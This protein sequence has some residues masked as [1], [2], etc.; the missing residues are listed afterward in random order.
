MLRKKIVYILFGVLLSFK[1]F[2]I[3]PQII[4]TSEIFNQIKKIDLDKTR[5]SFNAT[6]FNSIVYKNDSTLFYN[7]QGTL[8]LFKIKL[9]VVTKVT[10][11]SKPST[12][13]HAYN[14][15]L[16]FHKNKIYNYGGEGSFH[17][18]PGLIYF[19]DLT[20]S[21]I[22]KEITNYPFDSKRVLNS[23]KKEGK[24]MVLLSHFSE[25]EQTNLDDLTKF[26]FG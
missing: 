21:W 26:S 20:S 23:W 3:K 7:P 10:M 9:G 25:L 18:F 5:L 17:T 11:L 2:S 24:V 4:D 19:D 6:F 12:A 15:H 14:S 16:F 22:K 8:L 13:S 1:G